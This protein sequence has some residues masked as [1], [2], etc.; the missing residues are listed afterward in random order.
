MKLGAV[1]SVAF[2]AVLGLSVPAIASTLYVTNTKSNSLSIIDTNTLEVVGTIQLGAGNPT[3]SSST[4]TASS[5]GWSS[6]RAT[7]SGSSTP[8]PK[9]SCGA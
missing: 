1:V 4:P 2:L 3:G 9:S 7:I 8:T 6:T 5:R